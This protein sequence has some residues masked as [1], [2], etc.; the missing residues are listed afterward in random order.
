M[1]NYL[2]V[3]QK[4]WKRTPKRVTKVTVTENYDL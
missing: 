1:L 3:S 2:S 4:Q